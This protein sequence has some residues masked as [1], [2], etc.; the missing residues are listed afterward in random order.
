MFVQEIKTIRIREVINE[1]NVIRTWVHTDA[2]LIITQSIHSNRAQ[3]FLDDAR[4]TTHTILLFLALFYFLFE[5]LGVDASRWFAASVVSTAQRTFIFIIAACKVVIWYDIV[6]AKYDLCNTCSDWFGK[7]PSLLLRSL[8]TRT[9]DGRTDHFRSELSKERTFWTFEA[10]QLRRH[11]SHPLCRTGYV[12]QL[13]LA[14]VAVV[15]ARSGDDL[16]HGQPDVLQ[17]VS[18]RR[19]HIARPDRRFRFVYRRQYNPTVVAL[20][21]PS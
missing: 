10:E 5:H 12:F 1:I 13:A 16:R 19:R 15:S 18:K 7:T 3:Y 21:R 9:R 8:D 4:W 14:A 2:I 20:R 11:R 17:V 6:K